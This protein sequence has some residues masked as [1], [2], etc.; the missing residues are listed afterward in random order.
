MKLRLKVKDLNLYTGNVVVA[1]LHA[2]DAQKMDLH[3]EDRIIIRKGSKS[4]IAIVDIAQGSKAVSEGHIG[5]FEETL[6][7]LKA[8][9]GSNVEISLI[10][11]P[12]SIQF[13]KKKL[14][15]KELSYAELSEIIKDVV[16]SRLSDIELA[17]FVAACFCNK[18]SLAETKS[19]TR[20]IVDRGQQLKPLGYPTLDK[21]SIGGVPGN[22]TTMVVVPIVCAAG[23]FMP[24]TSSRSIS[25]PAGTADT[26]EVLAN[27]SFS[28]KQMRSIVKKHNGC[29]IWGGAINLASADDKLIKVR[30]ALSLDPEGMLLASILAKKHS[31]SAT[32]VLVDIPIGKGAKVS[33]RADAVK[34]KRK[35]ESVAKAMGMHLHTII[36]DGSQPIGNGIGPALEARDVVWL[37]ERSPKRPLDLEKKSIFIAAKIMAM[38]GKMN[39]DSASKLAIRLLESGEAAKKFWDIIIAQGGK[40]IL[41]EKIRA[42]GYCRDYKALSSGTI[43]SIDNIA[44]S[45]IAR[46]AGAPRDKRSGVYLHFHVG[47]KV[48][49]GQKLFT[50]YSEN[51][52]K[53]KYAIKSCNHTSPVL[54]E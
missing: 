49:K 2:R 30:H 34:L 28:V 33:N 26:V 39:F 46:I 3:T 7:A 9:T 42:G 47:A 35:F 51:E 45:K 41:A 50:V 31:V 53:M 18:L 25:S 38:S 15:G 17:Y 24:K 48:A 52:Q 1:A 10:D 54:I 29:M 37:L 43:T 6:K 4:A 27:V 12:K 13:I 40:R 11:K 16:Q 23:F 32:H 14:N 5:L 8:R 20:A 36:T 22:R 19:L 21:H 44:I